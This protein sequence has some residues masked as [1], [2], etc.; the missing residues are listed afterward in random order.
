M[1][2]DEPQ[3]FLICADVKEEPSRAPDYEQRVFG[4]LY[5]QKCDRAESTPAFSHLHRCFQT[6]SSNLPFQRWA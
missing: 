3:V 4:H 2:S 1:F 6:E 5:V